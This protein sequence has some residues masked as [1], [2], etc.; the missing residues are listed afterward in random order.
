MNTH[1]INDE[2]KVSYSDQFSV[3]TEEEKQKHFTKTSNRWCIDDK[4]RHMMISL[5]WSNK[6][7]I[8][9]FLSD[10]RSFLNGFNVGM[11]RTLKDYE[12]LSKGDLTIC[13]RQGCTFEFSY[14]ASDKPVK[15]FGR[16]AAVKLGKRYYLISLLSS[17]EDEEIREATFDELVNGLEYVGE[18]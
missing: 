11:K 2:V 8:L 16:S 15:M 9:S 13:G 4:D 3:M 18:Q 12:C 5:G 17:N 1:I 10:T 6:L 14:T 7:G